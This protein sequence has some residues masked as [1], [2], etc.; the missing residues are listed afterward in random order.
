MK[1]M[2]LMAG[3]CASSLASLAGLVAYQVTAI[4]T[5]QTGYNGRV[6]FAEAMS[7]NATGT[8]TV[9]AVST[10]SVGG[11][12]YSFTNQL[13]SVTCANGVGTSA[14]TNYVASKQQIVVEGTAFPGGS[15]ILWVEDGK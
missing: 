2:I 14:V 6:V 13:C 12:L 7:T 8:A 15:V 9:S 4:N 3:L 10:L 11:K 5:P 1:K